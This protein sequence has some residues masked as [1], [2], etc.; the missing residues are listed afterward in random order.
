[1]RRNANCHK[2]GSMGTLVP[3]VASRAPFTRALAQRRECHRA[4]LQR[5]PLFIEATGSTPD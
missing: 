4:S 1:M 5:P 2:V 3:S